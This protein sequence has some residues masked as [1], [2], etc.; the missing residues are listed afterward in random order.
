MR[1][2]A[3]SLLILLS[4]GTASTDVLQS[5]SRVPE[6]TS[7]GTNS[8]HD[9]PFDLVLLLTERQADGQY[10]FYSGFTLLTYHNLL[11]DADETNV[12]I[13]ADANHVV[14]A[15]GIDKWFDGWGR[16]HTVSV[17]KRQ[18]AYNS[19]LSDKGIG[20]PPQTAPEGQTDRSADEGIYP[21]RVTGIL[22]RAT[23]KIPWMVLL[24]RYRD[25]SR[26]ILSEESDY[27]DMTGAYPDKQRLPEFGKLQD[28]Q[29]VASKAL[30]RL[31]DGMMAVPLETLNTQDDHSRYSGNFSGDLGYDTVE[32]TVQ[33]LRQNPSSRHYFETHELY[34]LENLHLPLDDMS[35]A[36]P[37]DT[38]S[39]E[40]RDY[41][42]HS[43]Y[44]AKLREEFKPIPLGY[45][46]PRPDEDYVWDYANPAK[47]SLDTIR[48]LRGLE[49]SVDEAL[50]N[51]E[52][53][54]KVVEEWISQ[55]RTA[56]VA[57]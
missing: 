33:R 38:H 14:V 30:G 46:W 17:L 29:A 4:V 3:I 16:V 40:S 25:L 19:F 22:D 13:S 52:V 39:A 23:L 27:R 26:N 9:P 41:M 20:R 35:K 18:L 48:E 37:F 34:G 50:S 53:Y 8:E 49:K 45:G 11:T 5:Y 32:Q 31:H 10:L 6:Q 1:T 28:L 54:E 55:K 51:A 57:K 43:K 2:I 36:P 44:I 15:H 56:G 21:V 42:D 7:Q 24:L 47:L 12:M